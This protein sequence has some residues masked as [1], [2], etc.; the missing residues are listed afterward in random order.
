LIGQHNK[1]N[2]ISNNPAKMNPV[3]FKRNMFFSKTL[4]EEMDE[5]RKNRQE[6]D[7]TRG[8]LKETDTPLDFA[9]IRGVDFIYKSLV[10]T[11]VELLV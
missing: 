7:Y 4:S 11:G 3:G 8:Q 6:T 1:N 9:N 5:D 10:E 2:V